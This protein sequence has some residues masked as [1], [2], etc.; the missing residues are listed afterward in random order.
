MVSGRRQSH[1]IKISGVM[2]ISFVLFC[3]D[4]YFLLCVTNGVLGTAQPT[5]PVSWVGGAGQ[6]CG[7]WAALLQQRG[8][9]VKPFGF[10]GAGMEQEE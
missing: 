10:P 5:L 2:K 8:V 3:L 1:Q 6:V 7:L 9:P 4:F